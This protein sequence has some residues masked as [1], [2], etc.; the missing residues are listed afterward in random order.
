MLKG[1]DNGGVGKKGWRFLVIT[2]NQDGIGVDD[3]DQ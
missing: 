2:T 1:R 3:D